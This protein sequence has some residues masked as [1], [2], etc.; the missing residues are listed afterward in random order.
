MIFTAI[1]RH[2]LYLMRFSIK[3]ELFFVNGGKKMQKLVS[4]FLEIE[5]PTSTITP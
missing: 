1:A 4:F 3:R 5:K 2:L